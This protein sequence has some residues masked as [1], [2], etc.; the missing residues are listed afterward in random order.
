M[1]LHQSSC[2]QCRREGEKLFLKG[3]R[4]ESPKCAM[5]KKNYPPGSLGSNRRAKPTSYGIQLRE[6]QKAKRI[7]GLREKQ[8]YKYYTIAAK[9]KGV[10]GLV[11]LQL[12]ETRL[13]NIIFRLGW[14][15]S[16]KMARQLV[17]HGHVQVNSHTVN[18]PSCQIKI[19]DKITVKDKAKANKYFNQELN[20]SDFK[21]PVWIKSETKNLSAEIVA[22]PAK[23]D[24][25][26]NINEQLII[27][28]YSR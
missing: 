18:I 8:F 19:G 21:P 9:K 5:I 23:D 2:R 24:I 12:L 6:K 17:S 27:E 15:Y 20:L 1:A 14:A 28:F 26:S 4:C 16:R 11:L 3:A 13:D 10:T 22:I 25:D 7:Y